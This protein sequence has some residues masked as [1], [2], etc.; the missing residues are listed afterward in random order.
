MVWGDLHTTVKIQCKS[1]SVSVTMYLTEPT[2][3]RKGK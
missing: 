3:H 1:A 2:K